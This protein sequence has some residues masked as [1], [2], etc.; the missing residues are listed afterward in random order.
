[1]LGNKTNRVEVEE[2]NEEADVDYN[3]YG[4]EDLYY[5]DDKISEQELNDINDEV[6]KYR[7]KLLNYLG[8]KETVQ[9][10]ITRLKPKNKNDENKMK[11]DELLD[12]I[13]KLTELSYFDVYSDTIDK[14]KS[15]Y[16]TKDS[17]INSENKPTELK[18]K[19]K[20]IAGKTV[21]EFGPFSTAQI[22]E[23]YDKVYFNNIEIS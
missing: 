21:K 14:I 6:K 10:A 22:Q 18:W 12:I 16:N 19:Y 9:K 3:Y 11:F 20:T 7:I 1:M 23:W 2:V 4:E 15:K 8:K 13:S 5:K 17:E